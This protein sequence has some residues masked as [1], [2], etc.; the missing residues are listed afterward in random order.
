MLSAFLLASC[1]STLQQRRVADDLYYTP[2]KNQNTQ[3]TEEFSKDYEKLL[4]EEDAKVKKDTI[5]EESKKKESYTNPYNEILVD[6]PVEAYERRQKARMSPYYGMNNYYD[7]MFS[8]NLFY[9]SAF[10]PAMYNIIVMGRDVWVEPRWMSGGYPNFFGMYSSPFSSFPYYSPFGYNNFGYYNGYYGSYYG[11]YYGFG[12]GYAGYYGFSPFYSG[13][14][15]YSYPINRKASFNAARSNIDRSDNSH[16][17]RYYRKDIQPNSI[18]D[19]ERKS[20]LK[21]HENY[22]RNRT[23]IRTAD[24]KYNRNTT[25]NNRAGRNQNSS[26]ERTYNTT[27]TVRKY[28]HNEQNRNNI[29]SRRYYMRPNKETNYEELRNKNQRYINNNNSSNSSGRSSLKRHYN[30]HNRS[31]SNIGSSNSSRNSSS[32]S[33]SS[34]SSSSGRKKR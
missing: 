33:G 27:N 8:D 24:R 3:L 9:A 15:G 7:V 29:H 20:L 18:N 11:S 2:K 21:G 26:R 16:S 19:G 14:M 22:D 1:S 30:D 6:D 32:S 23:Y 10:D 5:V 17:I 25:L 13:Y 4:A 34:S 12:Y 31:S 28:M